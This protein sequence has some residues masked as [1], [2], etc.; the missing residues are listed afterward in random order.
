ML[1]GGDRANAGVARLVIMGADQAT[2]APPPIRLSNFLREMP[3]S[4]P[5]MEGSCGRIAS[6]FSRGE[7]RFLLLNLFR[8]VRRNH[9][10]NVDRFPCGEPAIYAPSRIQLGPAIAPSGMR[11]HERNQ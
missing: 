2:T 3:L 11:S 5:S 10:R 4:E 8:F 9:P 1:D 7:G 6:P